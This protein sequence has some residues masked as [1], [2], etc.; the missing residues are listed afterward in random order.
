VGSGHAPSTTV[1]PIKTST[2]TAGK[3]IKVG[4]GPVAIAL[5]P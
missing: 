2:N 5:T 4:F 1:T 3:P